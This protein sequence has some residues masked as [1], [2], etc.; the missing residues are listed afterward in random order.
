MVDRY[1]LLDEDVPMLDAGDSDGARSE[2]APQSEAAPL[3]DRSRTR[4]TQW[5]VLALASGACAA[6]NGVFAKLSVPLSERAG[7]EA[8]GSQFGRSLP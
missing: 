5:I 1:T 8:V 4:R 3:V 7:Q 2:T 6:F